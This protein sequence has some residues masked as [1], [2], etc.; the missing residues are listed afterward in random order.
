V[1]LTAR[2]E[3]G[4]TVVLAVEDTGIGI[5]PE[6]LSRIF[7]LFAQGRDRADRAH[8]GLGIGLSL[9][10]RL[11][12]LHGGAIAAASAGA[13]RGS[14]FTVRLPVVAAHAALPVA[15][16]ASPAGYPRIPTSVLIVDDNRDA[17]D[18][19]AIFL[20]SAGYAVESVH[21]GAAALDAAHA[22]WPDVVLLDL[23]LPRMDG[24]EVASR[25]R[26]TPT[27][28]S[29]RLIA[30]SG[31]GQEQDRRRSASAGFEHHLV[32]PIDYDA[33]LT[34]LASEQPRATVPS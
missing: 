8:G 1:H 7:E 3:E 5:E 20:R 29:T 2:L 15:V 31:Y 21:D 6:M 30:I 23:G 24:Y 26:R 25:L 17:A 10:R 33:L 22:S 14:T 27:S 11:T 12:E 18:A 13:G 28:R 9:A 19:L 16:P 32:K 34:L 4:A